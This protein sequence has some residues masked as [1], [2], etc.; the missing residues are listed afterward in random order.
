MAAAVGALAQLGI[1]S[2]SPITKSFDWEDEDF[3]LTEDFLDINGTRGTRERAIERNRAGLQHL[4][5]TIGFRPTAVEAQ[6][7]LPWALGASP[8]GSGTITYALAETLPSRYV[9]MDRV[10]KVFTYSTVKVDQ[11]VLSC[12]QGQPLDMSLGLVG[13]SESIG[14]AGTFPSP[15]TIDITTQPWIMSDL[16]LTVDGTTVNPRQLSITLNNYIDRNRFFNGLTLASVETH[17]RR[18]M[19][20]TQLPYGDYYA[21]YN[22][23]AAG[24]ACV[25]TFTNPTTSDILTI[26]MP[27]VALPRRKPTGTNRGGEIMLPLSGQ[28]MKSGTTASLTITVAGV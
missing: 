19:F 27:K 13:I 16:A 9:V 12:S 20:S 5:G 7:L 4:D 24:V 23:G 3:G 17:D 11:M 14:N 25:A 2:S 15:L 1:D 22:T 6:L 21:L 26:T 10:A 8:S 18:V 28:A